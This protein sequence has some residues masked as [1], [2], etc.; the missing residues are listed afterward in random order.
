[1]IFSVCIHTSLQN[2]ERLQMLQKRVKRFE[3]CSTG[4]QLASGS[5]EEIN[6]S[7]YKGQ[8]RTEKLRAVFSKLAEDN[9]KYNHFF[10]QLLAYCNE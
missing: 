8:A 4:Q 3:A 5:L 7:L 6:A 2:I 10:D 1:M 9:P